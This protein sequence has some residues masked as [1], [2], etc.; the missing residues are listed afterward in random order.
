MNYHQH[1]TISKK[2]PNLES[3]IKSPAVHIIFLALPAM[4][5]IPISILSWQWPF[6][7]PSLYTPKNPLKTPFQNIPFYLS[8]PT[9]FSQD[10]LLFSPLLHWALFSLQPFNALKF[11]YLLLLKHHHLHRQQ[12]LFSLELPIPSL[13]FSSM[14]MVLPS[15]FHLS[16]RISW[17]LRFGPIPVQFPALNTPQKVLF[18][19]YFVWI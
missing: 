5:P 15:G 16:L 8:I 6:F 10:D 13:G 4:N 18:F 2:M 12:H 9:V 17:S 14:V 19:F 7:S 3:L 1:P 11:P